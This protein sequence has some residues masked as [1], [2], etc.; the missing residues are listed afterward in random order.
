[1][2]IAR[3]WFDF[4]GRINRGKYWFVTIA[5]FIIATAFILIAIAAHSWALGI[6]AALIFIPFFISS[7]AVAVKRLH[8]R[9]KSAWWV[10]PFY[11]LPSVLEGL[12]QGMNENGTIVTVIG[13]R[14]S[15]LEIVGYAISLWALVE[16][17]CLRGTPGAN[18]YG[19]DPLAGRG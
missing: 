19:P 12:G 14:M 15:I 8:D 6:L 3:I 17:G 9:N 5:N 10:L 2:D 1:V 4:K 16:L 11:V 13:N 18:P 7:L